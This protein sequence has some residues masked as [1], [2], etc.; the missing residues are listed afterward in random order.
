MQSKSQVRSSASFYLSVFISYQNS[1]VVSEIIFVL[2]SG[3]NFPIIMSLTLS[4]FCSYLF[5]I[6]LGAIKL[7]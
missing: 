1:E 5:G 4:K 7:N 2:S 3:S 6:F